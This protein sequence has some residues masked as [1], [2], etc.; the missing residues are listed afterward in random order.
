MLMLQCAYVNAYVAHFTA[1]LCFVFCFACAYVA[2]ES[3][4]HKEVVKKATKRIFVSTT[5]ETLASFNKLLS[6]ILF[7]IC[8]FIR[9]SASVFFHAL[10]Q[11][12]MKYMNELIR[13]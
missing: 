3:Q 9:G 12:I 1:F 7:C 4:Y 10:P 6:D 13:A 8:M 2:C 11:Y 5:D